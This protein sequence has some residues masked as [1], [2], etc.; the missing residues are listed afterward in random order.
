MRLPYAK[1]D[2]KDLITGGY[3][4]CD[5]TDLI[6]RIDNI[7]DSL[8]FLRPRRFGK[9]LLLSMLENYYDIAKKD[10]FEQLFG[11]LKISKN[12]TKLCSSY[13]IL[14]F[15]FSYVSSAGTIKDIQQ[16]LYN[17]VNESIKRFMIKYK[18]VIP[19][20][21]DINPY[22]ALSSLYSL[23]SMMQ[24][25]DHPV[26]LLIDEYDNFANELMLLTSPS[27]LD[28]SLYLAAVTKDGPLRTLFKVIK[29][30]AN[31]SGFA[32]TF[33]TGVTP[34]VMSDITSGYNIAENIYNDRIFNG[35]CGFYQNEV[36]ELLRQVYRYCNI[37]IHDD[38][39]NNTMLLIKKY[40]NGHKFSLRAKEN[41]YNPT[42]VIYF[43]KQFI[44]ECEPPREMMDNNLAV[45]EQKIEY[46]SDL[47]LGKEKVFD[48]SEKNSKIE[49][50][51][52]QQRFGVR[53]LLNDDSK[54][55]M[56]IMSYL[57]YSGA[58]TIFDET[59]QGYMLLHIPNLIMKS[60]YI[61]RIL[62]IMFPE[63]GNRDN[64][65]LAGKALFTAGNIKPVCDFMEKETFKVFSNRDYAWA[66][67]LTIKTAFLSL[68][69]NDI[70][71]IMDSE[72]EINKS[73]IDLTMIIRPDKRHFEI[74]DILIEFKY[75]KLSKAK[76]SAKEAKKLTKKALK[77]LP[78]IKDAMDKAKKQAR[79]YS[80][81]LNKKYKNLKLKS[82]AVVSF[83]FERI[84]WEKA[85]F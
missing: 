36:E 64:G 52:L 25:C 20:K 4:Y 48:L 82:F 65:L 7:G 71:Y 79:S 58:L 80:G 12:L 63:P 45:D 55:S 50:S 31:S 81:R 70:L 54:D 40:F 10:M 73:Y 49:I 3:Y 44:K 59:S 17:H 68:L 56:F 37:N 53:D 51:S 23:F 1:A 84:C 72:K 13:F 47:S 46:V 76:L 32:K 15:D 77:E 2:F 11:H 62:R 85:I 69:Y 9:S 78:C 41:I 61:N 67:E 60:L 16:S 42:A 29:G 27:S 35:L 39:F 30:E 28:E 57:Y 26:Y 66:N 75:V 38:S 74:F 6:P 5:R 21:V 22:D 33:I 18:N 24:E 19:G 43:L 34:V 14:K 83:G 8:L